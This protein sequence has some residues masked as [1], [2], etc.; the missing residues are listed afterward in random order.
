MRLPLLAV[1]VLLPF[2]RTFSEHPETI[3]IGVPIGELLAERKAH[4]GN[5][6]SEGSDARRCHFR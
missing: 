1:G 6:A 2:W 3:P 5:D 4:N